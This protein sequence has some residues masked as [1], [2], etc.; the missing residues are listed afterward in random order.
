MASLGKTGVVQLTDAMFFTNEQK[1]ILRAEDLDFHPIFNRSFEKIDAATN[2][3]RGDLTE[4]Q[5]P[6]RRQA[7][8]PRPENIEHGFRS[9][10]THVFPDA[11]IHLT[12]IKVCPLQ[13]CSLCRYSLPTITT[14]CYRVTTHYHYLPLTTRYSPLTTHHSLLTT[15]YSLLTTHYSLLATRYSL[16]TSCPLVCYCKV[17]DRMAG[18]NGMHRDV[19]LDDQLRHCDLDPT[20]IGSAVPPTFLGKATHFRLTG[21]LTLE[22]EDRLLVWGRAN[23][24]QAHDQERGEDDD[25]HYRKR[26]WWKVSP[27]PL[28]ACYCVCVCCPPNLATAHIYSSSYSYLQAQSSVPR[29]EVLLPDKRNSSPPGAD[30]GTDLRSREGTLTLLSGDCIHAG[31]GLLTGRTIIIHVAIGNMLLATCLP[32]ATVSLL[33]T[34][35]SLLTTHYSLLTTRYSMLATQCSLLT[36]HYSL[37]AT[38]YSMLATHYSMLA[39]HYSLLATSILATCHPLL[40]S[41]Q[42]RH[43]YESCHQYE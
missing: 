29:K 35:Y 25:A 22:E 14:R 32:L 4:Q 28:H 23:D 12:E 3:G 33:T 21:L 10:L 9:V 16:L 15:R 26:G 27:L 37:L 31:K 36:T 38:C 6:L 1:A 40:L 13:H 2:G 11:D 20:A 18:K 8:I 42:L 7:A 17:L 5:P 24:P 39:A 34:R 19:P 43:Q 41:T 30:C